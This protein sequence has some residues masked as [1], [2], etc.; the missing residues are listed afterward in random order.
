ML[1]RPALRSFT[2]ADLAGRPVPPRVW[3]WGDL[4]PAGTLTLFAGEGGVGKT[5]L[6]LQLA[7]AVATGANLF[8]RGTK[9][10]PAIVFT[11]EDPEAEVHRR[12]DAISRATGI[13]LESLADVRVFPMLEVADPTMAVRKS[14][15]LIEWTKIGEQ[16]EAIVR[17]DRPSL[18]VLDPASELFAGDENNKSEVVAFGGRL[19][20]LAYE[21]GA[22]VVLAVH[23]SVTGLAEGSGRAGSVGWANSARTRLFLVAKKDGDLELSV[24]KSNFGRCGKAFDLKFSDGAIVPVA[25]PSPEVLDAQHSA[26]DTRF[27]AIIRKLTRRGERVSHKKCSIYAP[28]VAEEDPDAGGTK[29]SEFAQSMRRLLEVGRLRIITE[30]P[31]SKRREYLE[32]AA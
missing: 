20:R 25:A 32:V 14:A 4:I 16:V 31:P 15:G 30:G 3:L 22:A 8:G 27:T 5:Q 11:A 19:R 6:L 24:T 18:V 23:P 26:I 9:K 1:A 10:G 7:A 12:V 21:T 2:L 17:D 28:K 13:D 29:S